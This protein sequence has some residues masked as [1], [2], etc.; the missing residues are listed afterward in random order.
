MQHQIVIK[1]QLKISG[2]AQI[3]INIY[4]YNTGNNIGFMVGNRVIEVINGIVL[5]A[6][7]FVFFT[8]K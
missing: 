4:F 7:L 1:Y 2:L 6:F 3:S 5:M 8:Y